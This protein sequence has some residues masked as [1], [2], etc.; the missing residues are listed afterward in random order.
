MDYLNQY[1]RGQYSNILVVQGESGC[2][3]SALLAN[4]AERWAQSNQTDLTI[5]H[6]LGGSDKSAYISSIFRRVGEEVKTTGSQKL[7]LPYGKLRVW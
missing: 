6:F 2:G 1:A 5:M 7:S 4:W 3:K